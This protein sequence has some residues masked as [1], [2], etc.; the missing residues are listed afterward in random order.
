M[1]AT[2]P[3]MTHATSAGES[4]VPGPPSGMAKAFDR[5]R[6][7]TQGGGVFY[8]ALYGTRCTLAALTS[9]LDCWLAGIE[10]RKGLA[11]PW[12]IS[13][14]RHSAA[15]NK[16]LWNEYDWSKLGEEWTCSEEWKARMIHDYL[17]PNVPEAGTVVEIG[18]GGG[19]WTDILRQRCR[20]VILIDVSERALQLCR[21][22]FK[23][24]SNVEYLLNDGHT[25]P[26]PD[27]SVD[28]VWSYDVFVHINPYDT[29]HY[30]HEFARIL[31]PGGRAVLHHP[32]SA[33]AR[34]KP[35]PG[36]RS[37]LTDELVIRFAGEHGIEVVSSNEDL[38][39]P[40][41]LISVF[42]KPTEPAVANVHVSV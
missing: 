12:A 16:K 23:D 30:F 39:H 13:T 5:L 36:W 20:K 17:V 19:R 2:A 40:N 26:I 9:V 3:L 28:A 8:A 1:H 25:I 18:P 34:N 15:E 24:C 41:E 27:A 38:A 14:R 4:H 22:R 11:E 29:R 33:L 31:K 37:D 21:E 32:G 42:V 6:T 7:T 35:R 10:Q